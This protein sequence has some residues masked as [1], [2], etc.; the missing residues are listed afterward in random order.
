[1]AANKKPTKNNKV[2][3]KSLTV[4][5]RKYVDCYDGNIK[6]SAKRAGISYQ[7]AKELHTKTYYRHIL[8]ALQSRNDAQSKKDIADRQERQAF[9]TK[10]FR[11]EESQPTITGTDTEGNP[12]VTDIPP[13]M[14]D[15]LKASELLARSEADFVDKLALG[16]I[17]LDGEIKEIPIVFVAAPKRDEEPEG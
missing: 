16:G 15:R 12:I 11:G 9:W 14:P 6:D 7:Y 5:Q 17:D 2:K 3:T 4:K 10:V 13:K 8:Y 1:M